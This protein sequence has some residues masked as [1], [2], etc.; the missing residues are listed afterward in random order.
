[1]FRQQTNIPKA[2]GVGCFAY[3]GDGGLHIIP[4]GSTVSALVY[5]SILGKRML[6]T[7]RDF[8]PDGDYKFQDD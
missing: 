8:Y 6:P 3:N 5:I 1:M 2:S 7:A 4:K